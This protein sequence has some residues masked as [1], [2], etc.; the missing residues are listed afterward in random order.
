MVSQ[1]VSN[2][3]KKPSTTHL[4]LGDIRS[5]AQL[6]VQAV[7]GVTGIV[8]GVHQSVLQRVGVSD[9]TEA[10]KA[11][12]LTGLIYNLITGTT[13][14]TGKALDTAFAKLLTGSDADQQKLDSAERE[15]VLSIL[16]GIVGDHLARSDSGFAIPM[17]IRHQGRALAPQ[18]NAEVSNRLLLMIHGL[19]MSDHQ[20]RPAPDKPGVCHADT[21]SAAFGYTPLHLRYNTGLHVSDNGQRLAQQLEQL[22]QHWP[23]P[24]TEISMLTHSMGGLV[25]RSALYYAMR[26]ALSWP[27]HVKH[28]I[29]MGTPHQ[30]SP[31]ERAGHWVDTMLGKTPYSAP[32]ARLGGARSAGITDLRHGYIRE[33][34]WKAPHVDTNKPQPMVMLPEAVLAYAVAASKGDSSEAETYR[35]RGDGLVPVGSALGLASPSRPGLNIAGTNQWIAYQ[36]GH[37]ALLN[38]A[39][40]NRQLHHWLAD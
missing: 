39:A 25:A 7:S 18:T 30:G 27:R 21:L 26:D 16:N 12:G 31:L 24:V 36:T 29:F 37:M 8:E 15:K 20:W 3:L 23:R 32:F 5:F 22:L 17:Q 35:T 34:D 28:L 9:S 33:Q 11:N 1:P 6:A 40:V 13:S 2:P 4:R 14:L 19:C 38:S 10:G